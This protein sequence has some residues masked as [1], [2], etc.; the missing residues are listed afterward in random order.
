MAEYGFMKKVDAAFDDALART[1]KLLKDEGFGI[2]SRIDVHEKFKEKLQIEFPRY[3]ILGACNPPN[4]HRAIQ[5]EEGIG[6]MLPCNV[7]VFESNGATKVG[8]IRPTIAMGMI[9]NKDLRK[10]A[11]EIETRLKKVFDTL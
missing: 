7:I 9:D 1:E 3:V 2:L 11:E 4:A 5:A 10:I 8:I 6:L